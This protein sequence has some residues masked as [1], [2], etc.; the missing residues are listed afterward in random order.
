MSID[1][2]EMQKEAANPAIKPNRQKTL[3]EMAFQHLL[4]QKKGNSPS[5]QAADRLGYLKVP[6]GHV[7]RWCNRDDANIQKKLAEGWQF[8]NKTNFPD[9]EH[10]KAGRPRKEVQ[11]GERLGS[12]ITYRE[13]V[14]MALPIEDIHGNGKCKKAREDY[15]HKET[16][17]K[18]LSRIRATRARGNAGKYGGSI[19]SSLTIGEGANAVVID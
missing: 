2:T 1:V 4:T 10:Q 11:D 3:P 6:D 13:M 8:V 9:G 17:E 18:T 14:G 16:V 12:A 5:W 19:T 15:F 7:G